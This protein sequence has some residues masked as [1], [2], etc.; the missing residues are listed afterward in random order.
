MT[1]LRAVEA[2]STPE[3]VDAA[4]PCRI[5]AVDPEL[6]DGLPAADRRAAE[7]L[8]TA[9][10]LDVLGPNWEPPAC[11]PLRTF[12]LLIL[13]GL[14][15]RRVTVAGAVA[16]ELLGCGDIL[17]PWDEPRLDEAGMGMIPSQLEWRVFHPARLAVLDT[18]VTTVIGRRPQL[19]VN[20]SSRLLRRARAFAYLA[21]VTH[22]TRVEDKLLATLWHLGGN[23]GRVCSAG[24]RVPFRLT[25]KVL[26]EIIGAQRPTVTLALQ[27]LQRHGHVARLSG[28]GFLLKGGPPA[29]T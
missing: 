29:L 22:Q 8:L 19:L 1:A 15:G 18:H 17:R 6:A 16:T 13:E 4:R 23:W 7:R 27:R 3:G 11:D 20:F 9:P 12:G 5:L 10:V 25:H 28:G 2:V 24:V 26:G 14:I 21:A